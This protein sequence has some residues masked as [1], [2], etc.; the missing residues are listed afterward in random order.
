MTTLLDFSDPGELGCLIDESSVAA[1]EAAIGKGGLLKGQE[2]AKRLFQPAGERPHL[3]VRRRQ[4]SEGRQ[5][6]GVRPAVLE[7]GQHQSAW[8]LPGLVPAQHVSGEQSAGAGKTQDAGRKGGSRQDRRPRLLAR[9]SRRPYRSMDQRISF[10]APSGRRC[11][12]RAGC[13]RPHCRGDKPGFENRRSYW[14][15]DSGAASPEE[16]LESAS[17]E[18]GSWWNHWIGWLKPKSG[19][20]VKARGRLGSPRHEPIEPAPGRYV[21]ARA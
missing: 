14:V 1:R 8:P 5:A 21:K 3:A 16:W 10:A 4:L 11:H 15:S 9:D 7:F 19:K 6:A 20:E 18:P 13:Q 12:V 17:E 2:L